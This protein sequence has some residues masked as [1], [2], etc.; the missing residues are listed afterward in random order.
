MF[1][2]ILPTTLARQNTAYRGSQI[3][4]KFQASGGFGR[5]E[6][7]VD[8]EHHNDQSEMNSV[9]RN[10]NMETIGAKQSNK[11]IVITRDS[12]AES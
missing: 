6:Y 3:E 4:I 7:E 8:E 10:G 2:N 1:R 9:S 5:E 12:C 11:K